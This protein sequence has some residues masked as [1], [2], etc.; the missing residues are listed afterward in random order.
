MFNKIDSQCNL[1][2]TEKSQSSFTWRS[3]EANGGDCNAH[4][5][6]YTQ[7]PEWANDESGV[8][9]LNCRSLIAEMTNHILQIYC[10]MQ[11]YKN[12]NC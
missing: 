9:C 4:I 7:R 11:K 3:K 1:G 5:Y 8:L 6:L 12:I 10:A 2:K